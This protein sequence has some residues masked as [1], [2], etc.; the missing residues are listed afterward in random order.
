MAGVLAA[1]GI[2]SETVLRAFL[3]VPRHLFVSEAL[4]FRAYEDTS[5]PIGFGQTMS[6]P[7]T[8]ARIVQGLN[9]KGKERV[10]EVGTGSG[11]QTAVLAE[12]SSMVASVEIVEELFL[13][14]RDVLLFEL[15][16]RNIQTFR[17][18]DY[19]VKQSEYDA[20]VVSACADEIPEE[21]I[22][23]LSTGGTMMIPV[24]EG[25][26]QVI[27]RI[28]KDGKGQVHVETFGEALFVPLVR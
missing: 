24:R 12:L 2:C 1:K 13:R 11:Y 22:F 7:S 21:Y 4:R 14:A 23:Q 26:R 20:I 19:R 17:A 18:A 16:Y 10:L 6:R 8:V 27:K 15:G 9:L 25:S 3:T 5:L 28:V